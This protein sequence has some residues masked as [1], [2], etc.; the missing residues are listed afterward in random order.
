MSNARY[1]RGGMYSADMAEYAKALSEEN[2]NSDTI[3]ELKRKLMIALRQEVTDKQRRYL[4]LYY[5]QG[6]N[7]R[8]ISELEGVDKSTVSRTIRRGECN[9]RRCLR[10]GAANLL[11]QVGVSPRYHSVRN[12]AKR[13]GYENV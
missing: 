13:E 4:T 10:F 7:M 11:D 1:R 6:L 3:T 12:L 8:E 9:L 2:T 5:G